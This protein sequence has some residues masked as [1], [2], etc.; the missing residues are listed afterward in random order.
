M[1]IINNLGAAMPPAQ[2]ELT[3]WL[4]PHCTRAWP[5]TH[6]ETLILITQVLCA[7]A[8]VVL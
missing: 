4:Y 6:A 1:F 8:G 2:P 5:L 3:K 7:V